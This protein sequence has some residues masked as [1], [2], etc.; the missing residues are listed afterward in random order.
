MGSN[1]S[2][3]LPP[4][5]QRVLDE[6]AESD[7]TADDLV[8]NLTDTQFV[9]RPGEGSWSIAECLE[10]LATTNT[11]YG[12]AMRHGIDAARRRG[13]TTYSPLKPGF[14]GRKFINS[15]EPP[16]R[17]RG[18]APSQVRPRA[19]LSRAE[20]LG[21]YHEAHRRVVET[22]RE[23]AGVDPNRAMFPNPFFRLV[24]VSVATGMQVIAAH[25]RRHLWQA[26][27]VLANPGFPK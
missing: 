16:V 21:R 26:R 7:R 18:R 20:I 23:A 25:D 12:D 1:L 3:A 17:M 8:A 14:F 22:I 6:I 19:G 2:G 11:V 27:Q 5:I 9:W 10:H 4:D 15:M 24:R 13:F